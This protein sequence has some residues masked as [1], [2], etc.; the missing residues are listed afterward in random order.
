MNVY[1]TYDR[2]EH[3]EWYYVYNIETN[4]RRA[5]KYFKETALVDFISY[6]PDDCHSFQ[7]QRIVMSAKEYKRLCYLV[8]NEGNHTCDTSD[9]LKELLIRIFDED[10]EFEVETLYSTDGCSDNWDLIKFYCEEVGFDSENDDE[11][12]QAQE[13]LFNDDELYEKMLK[14]YIKLTY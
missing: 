7:L 4:K 13:I 1:L 8:E 5:I 3:D 12:N 14:K 6:G 11:F 10:D 2:Y 9:E